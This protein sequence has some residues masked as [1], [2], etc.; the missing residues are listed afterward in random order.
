MRRCVVRYISLKSF[1]NKWH[2]RWEIDQKRTTLKSKPIELGLET[3]NRCN[4]KCIMCNRSYSR[5]DEDDFTGLLDR[6]TLEKCMGFFE[7]CERVSLG[8]FGEP[9]LHPDY[10]EIASYIK[11][12]GPY[13]YCYTNGSLLNEK[14]CGELINIS[15]DEI[16]VSL[17]GGCR[18]THR[19]IRGV[20]NFDEVVGHLLRLKEMKKMMGADE[21]RI[22]FNIVAMNTVLKEMD[23]II[24]LA[25]KLDVRNIDMPNLVAQGEKMKKESPWMEAER[26]RDIFRKTEEEAQKRNIRF[27]YPDLSEKSG[28]CRNFFSSMFIT[29]DGTI[30][31]CPFERFIL[32]NLTNSTME[33]IWNSEKYVT[34]RERYFDEGIAGTCPKC[35]CWDMRE[36]SFLNPSDNSRRRASEIEPGRYITQSENSAGADLSDGKCDHFRK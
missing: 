24:D 16:Y 5:K 31:S 22:S 12:R 23:K 15:Y 20:D 21:P 8:G 13:V 3:T 28:D 18:D 17:G 7:C 27:N 35:T 10:I 2:N 32:G 33:D 1:M 36:E 4:S 25:V 29:W 6:A 9:F 34:L 26:S 30:L 14:L 11:D 19:R